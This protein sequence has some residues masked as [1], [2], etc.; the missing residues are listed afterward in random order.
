MKLPRVN[1][2]LCSG[3]G[4]VSKEVQC[5]FISFQREYSSM[6]FKT[7]AWLLLDVVLWVSVEDVVMILAQEQ[8]WVEGPKTSYPGGKSYPKAKCSQEWTTSIKTLTWTEVEFGFLV[9]ISFVVGPSCGPASRRGVQCDSSYWIS[10]DMHVGGVLSI[11][12]LILMVV[13][14]FM[15]GIWG[16]CCCKVKRVEIRDAA[17]QAHIHKIH[18]IWSVG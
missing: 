9:D 5:Q 1:K 18:C 15:F 3:G 8:Q 7:W 16:V 11:S 4:Q 17:S 10:L 6:S 2:E 14:H 13:T 12:V